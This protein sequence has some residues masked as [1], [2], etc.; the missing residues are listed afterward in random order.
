MLVFTKDVLKIQN[1]FANDIKYVQNSMFNSNY[2]N[3]LL[4]DLDQNKTK[5]NHLKCVA[6][7]DLVPP[8]LWHDHVMRCIFKMPLTGGGS[9]AYRKN[10][11][12]QRGGG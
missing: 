5:S 9:E 8:F 1:E 6:C 3:I 10:L 7:R 2:N 12:R 4:E 11:C